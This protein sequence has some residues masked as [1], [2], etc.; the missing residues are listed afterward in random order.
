MLSKYV[1]SMTAR[2]PCA[3][4][5]PIERIAEEHQLVRVDVEVRVRRGHLAR[6]PAR[7]H[8]HERT[9]GEAGVRHVPRLERLMHRRRGVDLPRDPMMALDVEDEGIERA[10][11]TGEVERMVA[12][13]DARD[14]SA[15]VLYVDRE[16][17]AFVAKWR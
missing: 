6:M 17:A 5:R 10:L 12:E 1:S 16:V 14:L 4:P 2:R 11:P 9:Q 8:R 15:A 3:L 13:G 7:H